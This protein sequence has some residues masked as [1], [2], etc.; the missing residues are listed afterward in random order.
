MVRYSA[1]THTV[2][3]DQRRIPLPFT[4]TGTNTYRMN[5]G[6][7]NVGQVTP[8]YWM[9]FAMNAAGTPSNAYTIRMET[10]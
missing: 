6:P 5:L 1:T 9:L 3:T 8:G 7:A 2:N 4:R 10:W